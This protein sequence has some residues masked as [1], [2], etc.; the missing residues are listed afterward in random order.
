MSL[1]LLHM[2]LANSY[3]EAKYTDRSIMSMKIWRIQTA[4]GALVMGLV[5]AIM[6]SVSYQYLT[7]YLVVACN[8]TYGEVMLLER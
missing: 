4:F 7:L 8:L 5:F 1:T 3:A 2:I 6:S